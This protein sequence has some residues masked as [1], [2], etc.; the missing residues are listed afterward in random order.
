MRL[1]SKTLTAACVTAICIGGVG[2]A[3]AQDAPPANGPQLDWLTSA[4][5]GPATGTVEV[6]EGKSTVQISAPLNLGVDSENLGDYTGDFSGSARWSTL[7]LEDGTEIGSSTLQADV[8]GTAADG[9]LFNYTASYP[10][11][12]FPDG[13]VGDGPYPEV[14]PKAICLGL[15]LQF[16]MSDGSTSTD[17]KQFCWKFDKAFTG[18]V[19]DGSGQLTLDS[20]LTPTGLNGVDEGGEDPDGGTTTEPS[21]P[22]T[23]TPSTT[24]PST[25]T[26]SAPKNPAGSSSSS[27]KPAGSSSSS[28][29]T[30]GTSTSSTKPSSTTSKGTALPSNASRQ[31]VRS[32]P[33]GTVL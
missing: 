1:K 20:A 32:V 12:A 9:A 15:A 18:A 27:T 13:G 5:S 10:D 19:A 2:S 6:A 24:T 17:R 16:N 4:P 28:T 29:K 25:T 7:F 30:S 23:T 8:Q 14:E 31:A 11:V 26:S 22:S 21:T 3:V 33:S